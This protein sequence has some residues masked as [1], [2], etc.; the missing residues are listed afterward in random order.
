[1]HKRT[2]FT[3]FELMIVI[4]IIAIIAAVAIPAFN[5]YLNGKPVTGDSTY[6][7]PQEDYS[8]VT[9]A[10]VPKQYLVCTDGTPAVT[11]FR[12]RLANNSDWSL[13]NGNIIFTDATGKIRSTKQGTQSC[14]LQTE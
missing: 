13:E 10:P 11:T 6:Y 8:V 7:A 5:N 9:P 12:V 14:K 4:C 3:L 2:G 1:M